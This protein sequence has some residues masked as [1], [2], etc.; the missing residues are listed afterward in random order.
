ML[1]DLP[2]PKNEAASAREAE[3]NMEHRMAMLE[4]RVAK[5]ERLL[6]ESCSCSDDD[7]DL[8]RSPADDDEDHV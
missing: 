4:E 2:Q 8:T 6:Q 1:T 3:T 7:F 5:L